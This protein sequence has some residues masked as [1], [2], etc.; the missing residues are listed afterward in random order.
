ML[1]KTT[2]AVSTLED[3][4]DE[5]CGYTAKEPFLMH[6]ILAFKSYKLTEIGMDYHGRFVLAI[7]L[8]SSATVSVDN[9]LINLTP[10]DAILIFPYQYHNYHKIK[11]PEIL[12]LFITFELNSSGILEDLKNCRIQI[13]PKTWKLIE[14][15]LQ[16]Y[17]SDRKNSDLGKNELQ[18]R[19][20]LILN[21]IAT[22]RQDPQTAQCDAGNPKTELVKEIGHYIRTNFDQP[23]SSEDISSK[24]FISKSHLRR[25]FKNMVGITLGKYIRKSRIHHA[26]SLIDSTDYTLTEIADKCGFDSLYSFSRTFKAELGQS[27]SNYRK[28]LDSRHQHPVAIPPQPLSKKR[29]KKSA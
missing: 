13:S 19:T 23:L 29:K 4:G 14:D 2:A 20:S 17:K 22:S 28:Y 16:F 21:E 27:P 25:L 5:Y 1:E 3:P 10:G 24:F 11:S 8:K 7:C 15:L 26:A 6:N 12:W 9:S 18:L